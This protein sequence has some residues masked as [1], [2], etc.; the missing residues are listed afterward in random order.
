MAKDAPGMRGYRPRNENGQLRDT[1][2][3]KHV[4][5]LEKQY[6]RDF[7]VRD[8][9]HVGTLLKETGMSSVNDLIQSDIGKK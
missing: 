5:T 6:R 7:G 1:R 2:D 3:D 4:G 9:M 8:D